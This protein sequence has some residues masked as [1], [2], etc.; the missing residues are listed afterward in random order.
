[1][2]HKGMQ[3]VSSTL[4]TEHTVA[5]GLI[6]PISLGVKVKFPGV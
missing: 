5:L 3:D 2:L 6:A 4:Q 1:M